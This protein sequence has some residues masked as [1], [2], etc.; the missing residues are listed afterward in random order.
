MIRK[1]SSRGSLAAG[2][3]PGVV[4]VD[5]L[6]KLLRDFFSLYALSKMSPVAAKMS[7]V[8]A[9]RGDKLSGVTGVRMSPVA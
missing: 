2:A 1:N 3:V 4:A 7:H 5:D 8:A 9:G 6:G